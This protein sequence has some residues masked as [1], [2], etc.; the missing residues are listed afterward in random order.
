MV[1]AVAGV[2][3]AWVVLERR[4][5]AEP[6]VAGLEIDPAELDPGGELPRNAAPRRGAEVRS[7]SRGHRS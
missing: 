6:L 4:G 1:G 5:G 3:G 2:A 7:T